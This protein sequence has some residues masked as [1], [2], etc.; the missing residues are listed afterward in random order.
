MASC[1]LSILG[2]TGS[3]GSQTVEVASHLGCH[4]KAVSAGRRIDKLVSLQKRLDIDVIYSPFGDFDRGAFEDAVL[5]SDMLM[6]AISDISELPLVLEFLKTGKRV[7]IA[8][9]EM[10][11]LGHDIIAPYLWKNLYPVDSEH[12]TVYVLMKPYRSTTSKVILTASGGA[13]RDLSLDEIDRLSP[14]DALKHPVWNMGMKITVDSATLAN[15]GIEL[16]EARVLFDIPPQRLDAVIHREVLVHAMIVLKDGFTL[17]G[18]YKPSMLLP[19][20]FALTYPNL[21]TSLVNPVDWASANLHFEPIPLEKYGMFKLALDILRSD[22]KTLYLLYLLADE[23]VVERYLN[24]KIT[25]SKMPLLAEKIMKSLSNTKIP[26]DA[27]EK[28]KWYSEM[29]KKAKEV[30]I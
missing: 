27:N 1:K 11:V 12:A 19:I 5:S 24:G 29:K 26:T 4:I 8:T 17:M 10:I 22:N 30:S 16:L 20:Q 14:Q 18:A 2:I 13:F 9:K 25:F 28:V 7:A 23:I 21:R 6:V 3:I 15:K